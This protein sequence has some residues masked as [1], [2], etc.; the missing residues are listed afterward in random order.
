MG[1][2]LARLA[3]WNVDLIQG[4]KVNAFVGGESA[5]FFYCGLFGRVGMR[6]QRARF[7]KA[8]S[9]L[10]EQ[11]PALPHAQRH[12]ELLFDMR[13]QQ[14]AIPQVA[15]QSEVARWQPQRGTPCSR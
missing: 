2:R 14:L 15:F 5:Q 13:R 11:T 8:K 7:S 10:A 3:R 12:A 1:R 6:N 9:K 4:P